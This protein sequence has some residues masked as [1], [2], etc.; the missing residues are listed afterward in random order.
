MN[1]SLKNLIS[2]A[3]LTEGKSKF[4]DFE[5]MSVDDAKGL[6]YTTKRN[7][8]GSL[9]LS[10]RGFNDFCRI[11]IE[12]TTFTSD[13]KSTV[14]DDMF[15]LDMGK[16]LKCPYYIHSSKKEL[17]VSIFDSSISTWISINGGIIDY[18]KSIDNYLE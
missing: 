5:S 15:L 18:L 16:K 8:Y 10:D 12:Y 4:H 1:K 6:W 17:K 7:E 13:L 3:V 2:T 11:D 14:C 9:R